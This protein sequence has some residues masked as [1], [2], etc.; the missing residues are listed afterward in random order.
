LLDFRPHT[1]RDEARS[2][3]KYV[4][5]ICDSCHREEQR[6]RWVSVTPIQRARRNASSRVYHRRQR[7]KAGAHEVG[8]RVLAN[9]RKGTVDRLPFA[10]WLDEQARRIG[11]GELARLTGLHPRQIFTIRN[12]Y[13]KAKGK[14]Y[15]VD[16]VTFDLVDYALTNW[17]DPWVMDQLY[18]LEDESLLVAA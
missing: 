3:I 1:W 7:R 15:A 4:Q 10:R 14:F 18:P 17:G 16:W 13:A 5:P 11:T 6:L 9:R 8:A 2:I 12:G